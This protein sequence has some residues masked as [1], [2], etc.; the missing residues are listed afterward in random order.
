MI[1][2]EVIRYG[3]D[4][5]KFAGD[6]IFAEWPVVDASSVSTSKFKSLGTHQPCSLEQCTATA[7]LCA[8]SIVK[9]CSDYPVVVSSG[10]SRETGVSKTVGTLNVHCGLGGGC[11]AAVHVG[12]DTY[13]RELLLVGD[14]IDQVRV[15]TKWVVQ[16][17]TF[18]I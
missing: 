13:R 11:V 15:V 4:I 8:A 17:R 5:L 6:A 3:G 7:A 12:D 16:Y 1:V 18:D 2:S 9:L 14:P 10:G